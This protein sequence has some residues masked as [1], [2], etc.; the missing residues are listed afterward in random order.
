MN[1]KRGVLEI[2]TATLLIITSFGTVMHGDNEDESVS[3][4][5]LG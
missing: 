1:R 3:N 4:V 2:F 5:F